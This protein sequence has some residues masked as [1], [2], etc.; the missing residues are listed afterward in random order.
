[1]RPQFLYQTNLRL[2]GLQNKQWDGKIFF[3]F[4][5]GL[6]FKIVILVRYI[7]DNMGLLVGMSQMTILNPYQTRDSTRML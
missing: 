4:F 1:M 3:F 6:F 2:F 5:R 7:P